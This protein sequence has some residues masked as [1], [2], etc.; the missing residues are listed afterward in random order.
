MKFLSLGA[1]II[2]SVSC[3]STNGASLQHD[4]DELYPNT[5]DWKQKCKDH[6]FYLCGLIKKEC[7]S[8]H[9]LCE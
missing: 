6:G 8:A 4:Q 1:L 3:L 7:C 2:A 5:P 9:A